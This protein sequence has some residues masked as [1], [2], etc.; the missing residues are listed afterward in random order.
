MASLDSRTKIMNLTSWENAISLNRRR[1]CRLGMA[2]RDSNL[3]AFEPSVA[4]N[5]ITRTLEQGRRINPANVLEI[6]QL[7]FER[8][9]IIGAATPF[10][11]QV[12][13]LRN[14]HRPDALK[15]LMSDVLY[16]A[17]VR[18]SL[19]HLHGKFGRCLVS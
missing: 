9:R 10:C 19:V 7:D 4:D 12:Q 11:G 13:Y 1:E 5:G 8:W 18:P 15:W 3:H 16:L 2:T 14:K 17:W 6:F